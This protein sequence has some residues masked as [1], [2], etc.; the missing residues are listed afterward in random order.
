MSDL[1]PHLHPLRTIAQLGDMTHIQPAYLV[2]LGALAS[3]PN[4]TPAQEAHAALAE[5]ITPHLLHVMMMHFALNATPSR[6]IWP[7]GDL[8]A[9]M[10]PKSIQHMVYPKWGQYLGLIE[11]YHPRIDNRR[12]ATKVLDSRMSGMTVRE[13]IPI[14]GASLTANHI[15]SFLDRLEMTNHE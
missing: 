5:V 15:D 9:P 2:T 13:F 4:T 11:R 12:A 1:N 10:H 3:L 7:M 6:N 14:I 8:I